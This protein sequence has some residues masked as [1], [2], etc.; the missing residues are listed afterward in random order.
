RPGD[1]AVAV[2]AGDQSLGQFLAPP[3]GVGVEIASARRLIREAGREPVEGRRDLGEQTVRSLVA[4]EGV[5]EITDPAAGGRAQQI[6]VHRGGQAAGLSSASSNVFQASV[7]HLIRTGN[8]TTP[9]NASRSPSATSA[10][11]SPS[12]S[13]A[14]SIDIIPLNRRTSARTSGTER[15]L[16]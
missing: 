1:G 12:P 4:D 2:H 15:P 3:L 14:S 13:P 8:F 16:I 11:P 7:A 6:L 9:C 5:P 10:E